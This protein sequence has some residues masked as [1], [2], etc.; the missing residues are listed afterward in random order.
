MRA[1]RVRTESMVQRMQKKSIAEGFE[2]MD[3]G[4]N[5]GAMR[6]F[7]Y[8]SETAPPFQLGPCYDAIA[9][10]LL[11]DDAKENFELAADKYDLIQ[12]PVLAQV[13]R[14]RAVEAVEGPE[15]ALAQA[16]ALVESV[17]AGR[18]A[19]TSGDAKTKNGVGRAFNYVAELTAVTGSDPA[20][21]LPDVEYAIACGWD[22]VHTSHNL[23][24]NLLQALGRNAEAQ[25]AFEAAIQANP[26]IIQAYEALYPILRGSD[27]QRALEILTKAI[28]H[29]PRSVF[30]RDQAFLLSELGQDA[31]A[32]ELLDKYIASPPHEETE[33][34]AIG[35]TASA[36]LLKAKAAVLA[37]QGRLPDALG[38]AQEALKYVPGDEEA[39]RIIADIEQ[40]AQE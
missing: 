2:L 14:I 37:D 16:R 13:M 34:L 33:S 9:T 7:I 39:Q 12:Q 10:L 4:Y 23:R 27:P 11:Q 36:T 35:G 38:A 5:L 29:H 6:L 25:Q 19:A 26:N 21:A 20:A 17:D 15:A 1:A 24:G 3:R 18:Q 22:R 40:T 31:A 30:I 8:K 28:E 32:L